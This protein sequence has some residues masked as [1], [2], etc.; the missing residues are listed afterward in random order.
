MRKLFLSLIIITV[1]IG[2]TGAQNLSIEIALYDLPDVIFKEIK[3]TGDFEKTYELKIKQP[4]DHQHPGKGYFYQRAFLS[5]KDFSQPT[6]MYISGYGQSRVYETEIT[7]LLNANQLSIEH[8]FFGESLPDTL[9]YNYLTL[10]QA[11]ADLHHINEIF[12]QIYEG[13]WLST[14]ISKGGATTIFYK[15][16]YPNDVDAG[17]PYV[18]PINREYE[19]KRIYTF[20]DTVGSDACREKILAFQKRIFQHRN[21][22][23]PLLKMYCQGARLKFTYLSFE[24][25]FE[26]SVLE[27]PFAFWQYGAP[28]DEI[29]TDT[30]SLVNAAQYLMKV[31]NISMFS[32]RDI[33]YYLPHYYQSASQMGYYG[34]KTEEF[35]DD[36]KVLPLQPHPH[37]ALVP[38]KIPVEFDGSLLKKI[39]VWTQKEGDHLIYIYGAAD[40][41]TASAVPPSQDVDAVWYFMKGKDHST[42]RFV[43]MTAAEKDKFISTLEKWLS[44][45]IENKEIK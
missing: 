3:N 10:E 33:D 30:S 1:F 26:Y 13:K 17:V 34:Y 27:Y 23:L 2:N 20:L 11:T 28:C 38:D 45:K 14:G 4:V 6:V 37:A 35:K 19:E 42:A 36:L 29:P 40:T 44:L 7:K 5:H 9:D 43:E 12:R 31:S 15:Y 32:D 18:A 25:A 41:W 22:V 39:N 16:F 8:R 24:E 21:E